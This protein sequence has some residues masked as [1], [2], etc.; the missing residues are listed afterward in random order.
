MHLGFNISELNNPYLSSYYGD[1]Q[2]LH[3]GVVQFCT[4]SSSA[5]TGGTILPGNDTAGLSLQAQDHFHEHDSH[6]LGT[7]RSIRWD[8]G[9]R[10]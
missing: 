10:I 1:L 3:L 5:P 2:V 6:R 7:L 4:L 9:V 8:I